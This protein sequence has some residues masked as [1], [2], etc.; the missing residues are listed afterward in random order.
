VTAVYSG[1]LRLVQPEVVLEDID[2]QVAAGAHH[3]TF[4]DPDFLNAVPHSRAI[5]E[6]MTGRHPDVSFDITTKVEHVLEHQ[7]LL[8]WLGEKGCLFIT[9]AFEST[10][11]LVLARLAKGHTANDLTTVV[12]LLR[13][14]GIA[15]RPTWVPFTPWTSVLDYVDILDF[16]EGT[17]LQW[18]VAPVQL[19]LKLL[20]P[21]GSP[22]IGV[23]AKDGL[24]GE[25]DAERLTYD[26][27]ARDARLNSLQ[28]QVAEVV[29]G[30]VGN[31]RIEDTFAQVRQVAMRALTGQALPVARP[32]VMNR[33]ATPRLT[34]DWFC[35]A[36]PTA[37]QLQPLGTASFIG[38][39]EV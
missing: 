2:Q 13:R 20:L 10:S 26:W 5:I 32:T 4:G 23:V 37:A 35:C 27:A 19:A 17:E 15:V 28:R 7:T 34:E 6:A 18:E 38:L 33:K 3:I 9:S 31:T 30:C 11:N 12:K 22:L 29:E 24:L 14:A 16:I 39:E 21:P 8:P 36:E 1:R 25:F